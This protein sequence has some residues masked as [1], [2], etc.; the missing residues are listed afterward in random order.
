MRPFVPERR[1]IRHT[2]V[3]VLETEAPVE[4]PAP[5]AAAPISPAA[6]RVL[7][8]AARSIDNPR[9]AGILLRLAGRER[10]PA[11]HGDRERDAV[12]GGQSAATGRP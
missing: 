11:G 12:T 3:T 1:V 9:L 8:S 2:R 5:D 6:A 4:P 7:R 10:P